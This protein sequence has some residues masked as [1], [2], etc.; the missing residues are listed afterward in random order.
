MIRPALMTVMRWATRATSSRWWLLTRIAAPAAGPAHER[1][2]QQDDA[3][4]VEARWSVRR[5]R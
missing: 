1:F 3:G 5:A 2:A 4:R